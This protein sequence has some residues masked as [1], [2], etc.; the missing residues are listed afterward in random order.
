MSDCRAVKTNTIKNPK[1]LRFISLNRV[2]TKQALANCSYLKGHLSV[3]S[4][5]VEKYKKKNKHFPSSPCQVTAAMSAAP[6]WK[7]FCWP[8]I[9][10]NKGQGQS[11]VHC[12]VP[13]KGCFSGFLWRPRSM[14]WFLDGWCNDSDTTITHERRWKTDC[15]SQSGH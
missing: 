13:E 12:Y 11:T 1:L 3:W 15:V 8:V 9:I 6:Q 7:E 5:E 2:L 14:K 10:V 4:L